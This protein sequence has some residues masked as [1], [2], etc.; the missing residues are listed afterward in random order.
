MEKLEIKRAWEG[1]L[2]KGGLRDPG[3]RPLRVSR[4]HQG[5]LVEVGMEATLRAALQDGRHAL[6]PPRLE[7]ETTESHSSLQWEAG[8]GGVVMPSGM[9]SGGGLH[10]IQARKAK[11]QLR[12][13]R[14]GD[15]GWRPAIKGG[16]VRAE[17]Q[18]G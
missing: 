4:G 17:Q 14:R 8:A 3:G 18:E 2:Q 16:R 10:Q 11:E 5:A 13:I 6:T 1:D 7:G 12:L 15:A 9:F